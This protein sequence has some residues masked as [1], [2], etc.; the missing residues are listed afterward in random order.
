MLD[1]QKFFRISR[2]FIVNINAIR[3]VVVY[4]SSRLLIRLEKEFEKELIVSRER[5]SYFKEWFNGLE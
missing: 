1:P 5:V 3:D 4:S 2:S